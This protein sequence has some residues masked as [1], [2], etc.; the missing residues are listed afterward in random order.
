MRDHIH[1]VPEA[2]NRPVEGISTEFYSQRVPETMS[3]AP[4]YSHYR[5]MGHAIYDFPT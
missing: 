5:Y 4:K 1:L 3:W 2:P